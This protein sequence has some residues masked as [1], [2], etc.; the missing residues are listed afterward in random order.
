MKRKSIY[1]KKYADLK[2]I[3]RIEKSFEVMILRGLTDL[4]R[5]I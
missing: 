3:D 5:T 1:N 4:E 2:K